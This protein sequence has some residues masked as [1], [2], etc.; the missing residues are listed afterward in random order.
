MLR[1]LSVSALEVKASLVPWVKAMDG[2]PE[3]AI[4]HSR[5]SVLTSHAF[6]ARRTSSAVISQ[7]K[8]ECGDWPEE[9]S[10]HLASV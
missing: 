7:G 10:L 1:E 2:Y 3:A 5:A 6:I 8:L 9:F 4:V